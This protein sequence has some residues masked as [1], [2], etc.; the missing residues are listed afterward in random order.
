[1]NTPIVIER[2]ENNNEKAYDLYSRLLKDRIIFLGSGVVDY[3]ANSI[4][5]QLLFLE[6]QDPEKDIY[7]YI[8]SPGG[9]VSAGIGIYDTMQYIKPDVATVCVG[10][11][12]SMGCFLLASGAKGKRSSLPHSRIMMHPISGGY[13]G[14]HPDIQIQA[15][16][17]LAVQKQMLELLSKHAGRTYAEVEEAFQRDKYMSPV[18]ALEFGFIDKIQEKSSRTKD[19]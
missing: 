6:S 16:E 1:M 14:Q 15:A 10:F 13:S 2:D 12:A 3:V 17:A 19:E 5:A 11:A 8:N 4:I 7:M 18:E 9:S